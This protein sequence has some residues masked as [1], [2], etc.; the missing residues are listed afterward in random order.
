KRRINVL[1][2]NTA[3]SLVTQISAAGTSFL[4]VDECHRAA[5]SENARSLQGDHI[6]TLGL[7][8]TPERDYDQLFDSV[9][10]PALGPIFFRYG[11]NEA[12]RD[13]VITPFELVN[14]RIPLNAAEQ[15]RY[16]D[17][18]RKLAPLLAM[19][20]NGHDVDDRVQRLLRE[21]ARV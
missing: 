14:V 9:V 2:L 5:S 7:S 15:R 8:A 1:V 12:R 21:R 19:R 10:V 4:I 13:G 18:T 16:D 17:L 6:A 20:E 11:Y 3:R